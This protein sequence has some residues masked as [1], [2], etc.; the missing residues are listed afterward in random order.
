[1]AY[2][3]GL[4]ERIRSVLEGR[5]KVTEK[6][7]FGGVAFLLGG[8]M[9]VGIVKG[10]LMVRVGPERYSDALKKSH[11][12]PMDF[13]GKPMKGYVF[14]APPGVDDDAALDRWVSL[15][16]LA[17]PRQH[18]IGVGETRSLRRPAPAGGVPTAGDA[19]QDWIEEG[20]SCLHDL[21][22]IGPG[23]R[24]VA[25]HARV[26][27]RPAGRWGREPRWDSMRRSE[28]ERLLD[29]VAQAS[30]I[31]GAGGGEQREVGQVL[32]PRV[33]RRAGHRVGV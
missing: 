31:E 6:K 15:V 3:E 16:G 5:P 4:A 17:P 26:H 32:D 14:V 27:G 30:A 10:D 13:T 11:V 28:A 9:F 23:E 19:L 33:L 2:D 22:E 18:A 25:G 21:F 12:R 7:M 8:K 1:M 20:A 29:R 24:I